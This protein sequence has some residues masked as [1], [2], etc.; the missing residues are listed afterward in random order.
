[1]RL[2]ASLFSIFLC[3]SAVA[4]DHLVPE[5]SLLSERFQSD[6]ESMVSTVLGAALDRDVPVRAIVIPSFQPEYAV[7]IKENK[8]SFTAF[9]R[10]PEQH[11]WL[12][13]VLA[14]MRAGR[15]SSESKEQTIA[16]IRRLE[17]ELP[18]D[19]RD[20]KIRGRDLT[21]SSELATRIARVWELML[22]QTR[23]EYQSGIG[24]DGTTY[25]F[26]AWVQYQ[27]MS[28]TV[29]SPEPTTLTG[30]LV[31][32]TDTLKLLC[33]ASNRDI[34]ADLSQQTDELLVQLNAMGN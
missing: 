33:I 24:F 14:G 17:A 19:Y 15:I 16:D 28:G 9:C 30:R 31:Q 3:G 25:H 7:G 29:W 34:R 27:L 12:F 6:Y 2:V 18:K 22:R 1:M 32:L 8:G 26:S 23:H 13:Q 20:V 10:M 5:H 11:L 21:I 4:Q